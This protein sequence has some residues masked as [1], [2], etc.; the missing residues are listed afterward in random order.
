MMKRFM[1]HVEDLIFHTRDGDLKS[2][3]S[4]KGMLDILSQQREP[5]NGGVISVKWDGAPSIIVGHDH[6]GFF[7]ARKGFTNHKNPKVYRSYFDINQD[8]NIKSATL[9]EKLR[10]VIYNEPNFGEGK[11]VGG[12]MVFMKDALYRRTIDGVE[13]VCFQPNMIE[14]ASPT[15]SARS[16]TKIDE[17]EIGIAWHTEYRIGDRA[18]D[19]TQIAPSG[20]VHFPHSLFSKTNVKSF[21][22]EFVDNRGLSYIDR[23]LRDI[24]E[25]KIDDAWRYISEWQHGPHK[26]IYENEDFMF[27]LR[28]FINS[29][30]KR[31]DTLDYSSPILGVMDDLWEFFENY[32]NDKIESFKTHDCVA[33]ERHRKDEYMRLL[34]K[35]NF[36]I[37]T[38]MLFRNMLVMPK[39]IM[40]SKMN[41]V[42]NI[43]TSLRRKDGTFTDTNHEGYVFTDGDGVVAKYIDRMEFSK[44]NF[45]EDFVRGWS[46]Y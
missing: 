13:H 29:Y 23:D 24:I 10:L 15:N 37:E 14:Y 35:N 26:E 36:Y 5:E 42:K 17:A 9:R 18:Q 40:I 31:G 41:E 2:I 27:L 30:I 44:V 22:C 32:H 1:D 39:N 11:A 8:K 12:D 43:K 4:L 16:F 21:H 33:R 19:L 38:I 34:E 20:K 3:R 45:S 46:R 7:V 28:Q 6:L 25:S